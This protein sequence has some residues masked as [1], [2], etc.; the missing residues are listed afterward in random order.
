VTETPARASTF[1]PGSVLLG[2]LIG[3]AGHALAF[4]AAFLA[5][6][7]VEPSGGGGF[8]DVAAVALTFLGIELLV[9][10]ASLVGGLILLVRGRRQLGAGLMLGW[11]LGAVAGWIF[12]W[13]QGG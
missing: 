10:I 1:S 9:T 8:E 11:L 4:G 7:V 2:V 12:I 13:A 3:L 5:G 6:Q